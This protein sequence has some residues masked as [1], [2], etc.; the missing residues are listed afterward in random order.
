MQV[1]ARQN[2]RSLSQIGTD[3]WPMLRPTIKSTPQKEKGILPH[4]L[5]LRSQIRFDYG[6]ASPH[7]AFVTSCRL[8]NIHVPFPQSYAGRAIRRSARFLRNHVYPNHSTP[9][10]ESISPA[11]TSA[12][13]RVSVSS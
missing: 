5:V 10:I 9:K 8:P 7:P 1:S 6:C 2:F 13:L 11:A 4:L 12:A 3:F